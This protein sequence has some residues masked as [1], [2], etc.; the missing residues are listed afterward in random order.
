MKEKGEPNVLLAMLQVMKSN[1]L[2]VAAL[3]KSFL[4]INS[5]K[6]NEE[7]NSLLV[8]LQVMRSNSLTGLHQ[9]TTKMLLRYHNGMLGL[10][11]LDTEHE[12]QLI[13]SKAGR[14]SHRLGK[15]AG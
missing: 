3:N 14:V 6:E 4:K 11:V 10:L 13:F 5:K 9:K 2:Q 15:V 8:M 1:G 12:V 7:H